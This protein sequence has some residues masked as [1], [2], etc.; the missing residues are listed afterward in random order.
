METEN[1]ELLARLAGIEEERYAVLEDARRQ[2]GREAEKLYAEIDAI[3]KQA[4]EPKKPAQK[5][6]A[7][8][9][10]VD[11]LKEKIEEPIEKKDFQPKRTTAAADRRQGICPPIGNG[12]DRFIY[13]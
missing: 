11:D 9:K 13:C 6:K 2:A 5:K 1:E 3:R 8:R 7:L 4:Q 12:W 10:Q